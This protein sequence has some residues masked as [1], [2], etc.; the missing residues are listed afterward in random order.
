MSAGLSLAWAK[1]RGWAVAACVTAVLLVTAL[2]GDHPGTSLDALAYALVA[3]SGLALAAGRRAPVPVLAVTGLCALG[4]QAIGFDLPALAYLFAVYAA[5]RAGHRIIT[6]AASVALLAI[7]PLAALA[8][9]GGG[10]VSDA[11]AQARGT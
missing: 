11:L 9:P 8:S 10:P 6:V 2:T 4:Y 1:V 7:L 5:V 3:M